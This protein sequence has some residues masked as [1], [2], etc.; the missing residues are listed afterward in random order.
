M[1]KRPVLALLAAVVSGLVLS[2]LKIMAAVGVVCAWA[3]LIFLFFYFS[4]RFKDLILKFVKPSR[5]GSLIL[6]M[7]LLPLLFVLSFLRGKAYE[8]KV[9]AERKPYLI[10]YENAEDTCILE[11][12]V[13]MKD[14]DGE[15]YAL[16]LDRCRVKGY[17]ENIERPAGG[18]VVYVKDG[19]IPKCGDHVRVYGRTYL[20]E[21]PHNPGEYDVFPGAVK[22]GIY[23]RIYAKK[24]WITEEKTS[25]LRESVSVMAMRFEEGIGNVFSDEDKGILIAMITGNKG[26]K[27]EKTEELYRRAGIGHIL[28]ISGL[29]V[30]LLVLGLWRGLKK[31]ALGRYPAAG[32]AFSFLLF[33][34]YF[35]GFAVSTVRAGIMCGI[36]LL[37]RL[38]RRH[39]DM[40]SALGFA[41]ILI[42]LIFP[43]EL[44]DPAFILSVTAVAGVCFARET[45]T[46][47]FFGMMV[48]FFTL[49]VSAY[50]FFEIPTYSF[51][52][53]FIVIPLTGLLLG[54]GICA[55]IFGCF[56]PLLGK[57][58]GGLA[59]VLLRVFECVSGFF[60]GL[61]FSSILIGRLRWY[62]ICFAYAFL[63]AICF[64]MRELGHVMK[65]KAERKETD[66]LSDAC[67]GCN[68]RALKLWAKVA[69]G[70]LIL[71]VATALIPKGNRL[72]FL[73][74]GQGDCG[75]FLSEKWDLSADKAED[76]GLLSLKKRDSVA[77][78]CG[79]TSETE[80]GER[81]LQTFLK[82]EGIMLVDRITVSHTDA[83]HISGIIEILENMNV[84]RNDID[85]AMRYRGNVGVRTLVMPAVKERGEAYN[86]LT[87]LAEKKNVKVEFIRAGGEIPLNDRNC[88]LR[89]LSPLDAEKSENETSL[90]FLLESPEYSALLMG[91]A[92]IEAEG[93]LLKNGKIKELLREERGKNEADTLG[94]HTP[95][96]KAGH[97]DSR[98][99][100]LKVGH[101]GSRTASSLEFLELVRPDVAVISCGH[102]NPYGHPHWSVVQTLEA[103]G[104]EVHR[105]DR[106][107]A[108][109]LP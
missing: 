92:G 42:L 77:F 65:E 34:L 21:G 30:S 106:E 6:M 41:M 66:R 100:I 22:D 20:I 76:Y 74:V 36:F 101:H 102:G 63:I 52:A 56:W 55:G 86:R 90:V 70:S 11:G 9:E 78:D 61:P 93:E 32:L 15:H 46:G 7:G 107:G 44:Y 48:T 57:V 19:E 60:S 50:F 26:Y 2:G 87:E 5:Y 12:R 47:P 84:Y 64:L 89:C 16:K 51:L 14:F 97:S 45:G 24:L 91:D 29:H 8:K 43:Y 38:V 68:H 1:I 40:Q 98:R 58:F 49:P 31:M 85:Y 79:S 62:E 23:S 27:T 4:D 95:I 28:A 37:G 99:L 75:V 80:V 88:R 71:L 3:L 104:A 108:V 103:V 18:C 96:L 39:Y 81:V 17:S 53:N 54:F 10:M 72:T 82:S 25:F 67:G 109:M 33:F 94:D 59:F 83:D 73:S 13:R 69:F 105:T 35:T